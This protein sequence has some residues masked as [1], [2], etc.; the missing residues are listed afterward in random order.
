MFCCLLRVRRFLVTTAGLAFFF[1]GKTE[2]N[3]QHY[4]FDCCI[5]MKDFVC[6]AILSSF[7]ASWNHKR[8][9]L[10]YPL[11]ASSMF[12][13]CQKSHVWP[14]AAWL[15]RVYLLLPVWPFFVFLLLDIQAGQG[16]RNQA[17]ELMKTRPDIHSQQH[18]TV[19][20]NG[21][22][23]VQV[24]TRHHPEIPIKHSWHQTGKQKGKTMDCHRRETSLVYL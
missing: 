6:N 12:S 14:P 15:L 23:D 18:R 2:Q 10:N 9:F 4:N 7:V 8:F 19:M 5:L 21:T 13:P 3:D 17:K 11:L 1:W 22:Y 16:Q 24:R 20:M